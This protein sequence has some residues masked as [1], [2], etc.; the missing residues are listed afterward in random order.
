MNYAQQQRDPRRHLFGIASVVL[1]HVI[2]IYALLTGLARK[3]VEVFKKPLEVSIIEEVK[4]ETPPPPPKLP[5]PPKAL[6]PPPRV[7]PPPPAY[8]PPTEV[9]V[10]PPPNVVTAVTQ[11]PPPPPAA[12][13]PPR[14]AVVNVGVACPNHAEVRSKVPYPPQASRIGLSGDVLLEFTVGPGGDVQDVTVLNATNKMF[15]SVATAAV[16]QLRCT[17]QGQAVRV[18]V[19][20]TFRLDT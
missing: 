1:I 6:R 16:N 17:G 18:R 8:V 11:A 15:V 20:F 9:A 12:V 10:A 13:S 14:P 19:P 4:V 2:V 3:V 5:P 7:V